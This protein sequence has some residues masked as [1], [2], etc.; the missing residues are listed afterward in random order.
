MRRE[1]RYNPVN[2]A[3]IKRAN[4]KVCLSPLNRVKLPLRAITR[5][6]LKPESRERGHLRGRD[7]WGV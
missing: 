7:R 2:L 5:V 6:Q 1:E 4:Q 3:E